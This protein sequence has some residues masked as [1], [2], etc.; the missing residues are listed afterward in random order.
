MKR[1]DTRPLFQYLSWPNSTS[2][3]RLE[4]ACRRLLEKGQYPRY[5]HLKTLLQNGQD[6]MRSSDIEADQRS[7]KAFVR[8]GQYYARKA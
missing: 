1:K 2:V 8:G 3:E 4:N 7:E 6:K 5:K